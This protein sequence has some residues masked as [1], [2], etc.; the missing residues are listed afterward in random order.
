M[1]IYVLT[2]SG[3]TG[4]YLYRVASGKRAVNYE[5]K[6]EDWYYSQNQADVFLQMITTLPCPCDRRLARSDRRWKKDRNPSFSGSPMACYYQ[7]NLRVTRATQVDLSCIALYR[8]SI[9]TSQLTFKQQL[10]NIH[11]RNNSGLFILLTH[12]SHITKTFIL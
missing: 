7:R 12:I 11:T 1:R 8:I 6:C 4:R 9:N 2:F 5:E 3:Q 10:T